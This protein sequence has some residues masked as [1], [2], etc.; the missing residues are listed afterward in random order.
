MMHGEP[1][2][3]SQATVDGRW[4]EMYKL[5]EL[6]HRRKW[7]LVTSGRYDPVG[8]VDRLSFVG[9]RGFLSRKRKCHLRKIA[10][11]SAVPHDMEPERG[12]NIVMN[13]P[14]REPCAIQ[15]G[16]NNAEIHLLNGLSVDN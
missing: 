14:R 1:K 5:R 2:G 3:L 6:P 12:H 8:V 10:R 4:K 13:R 11:E 16:D 9:I 7:T 15:I